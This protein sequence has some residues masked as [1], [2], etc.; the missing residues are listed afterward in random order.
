MMIMKIGKNGVC[1]G[2]VVALI[3]VA[4]GCQESDCNKRGLG[5]MPS[6]EV[7]VETAFGRASAQCTLANRG[8]Q[9]SFY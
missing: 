9:Y 1:L 8:A 7:F 2:F 5:S 4:L 3:F 6:R